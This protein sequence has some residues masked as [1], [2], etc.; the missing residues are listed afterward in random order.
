MSMISA[1]ERLAVRM[2][3]AHVRF[4]EDAALTLTLAAKESEPIKAD[5]DEALKDEIGHGRRLLEMAEAACH[6]ASVGRLQPET[7]GHMKWALTAGAQAFRELQEMATEWTRRHGSSLDGAQ[8]LGPLVAEMDGC[9]AELA[10][11][12]QE[13]QEAPRTDPAFPQVG[14]AEWGRMNQRRAELIRKHIRGELTEAERQEYETLQRSSL[15][16]AEASFPRQGD[17]QPPGGGAE[18]NGG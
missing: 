17:E 2:S 7:R 14:T 10:S 6:L 3:R 18:A 8:E 1:D 4:M 12:A 11:I 5:I 16:A 13:R 15:A 9:R